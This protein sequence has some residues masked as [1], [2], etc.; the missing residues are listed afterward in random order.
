MPITC[1]HNKSTR[2]E[3]ARESPEWQCE[4]SSLPS[5]DVGEEEVT[6]HSTPSRLSSSESRSV[7]ERFESIQL[8]T[9]QSQNARSP[10]WQPWQDRFLAA[11]VLKLR[12]FLEPR[13]LA[14]EAWDKL[15]EEMR[16]DSL[17]MGSGS[18]VKRTGSACRARFTKLLE[19]HR[20]EE[21]KSLQKTGTNEEID[22][23]IRNMT[24]I[25]SLI[26]VNDADR[27]VR[28]SKTK[29]KESAERTAALELR[30]AA[31]GRL[32][33]STGLTD[34]ARLDGASIRE[35]QGQRKRKHVSSS[36]P[37]DA[38]SDKENLPAK[39]A[40]GKTVLERVFKEHQMEDERLLSEA[41]V[42]EEAHQQQLM[43]G[44][45][46]LA[47]SINAL[48]DLSKTQMQNEIEKQR[49]ESAREIKL[50]EL[51]NTLAQRRN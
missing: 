43:G 18:E 4:D 10:R 42:R 14:Q 49:Q 45:D 41:R 26:D 13:S 21:T 51:M 1:S 44:I 17:K 6:Q 28:S 8:E 47:S 7:S 33:D 24:E 27:V 16:I 22:E 12:P 46:R 3:Q 35:K 30:D 48:V 39:R 29:Q 32:V 34:I 38:D 50:L 2:V 5:G 23:H 19:A 25:V 15:A 11:E 31:M 36:L 20:K 37:G 40:H 9:K